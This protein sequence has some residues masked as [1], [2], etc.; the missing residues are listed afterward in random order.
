M[1]FIEFAK[2]F[3]HLY[4]DTRAQSHLDD[5]E[6]QKKDIT[7]CLEILFSSCQSAKTLAVDQNFLKKVIDICQENASAVYLSELQKY[8]QNKSA[9]GISSQG[10]RI[11]EQ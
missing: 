2:V 4:I 1:L 7:L 3:K 9:K 5:S 6:N 11:F 10:Q 8:S